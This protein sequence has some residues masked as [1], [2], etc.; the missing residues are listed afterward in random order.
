MKNKVL[1]LVL[2]LFFSGIKAQRVNDIKEGEVEYSVFFGTKNN[3]KL[4]EKVS[5]SLKVS[6]VG[7]S[8]VVENMIS[9]N[10]GARQVVK[11]SN[12][13][14]L[15]I[16]EVK[17][18]AKTKKQFNITQ[19]VLEKRGVY[20][21][22]LSKNVVYNEKTYNDQDIVIK[23]NISDLKWNITDETAVINGYKVTK[24]TAKYKLEKDKGK[25][26]MRDVVAWF[27]EDMPIKVAPMHFYGLP[28]LVVKLE[29][30]GI[31]YLLSSVKGKKVNVDYKINTKKMISEDKYM[32]MTN[33]ID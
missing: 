19:I 1:L 27:S 25:Q 4:K 2:S 17:P 26:I 15:S 23:Y 8:Q 14:S 3:Q 31:S 5:D 22:D 32:D 7:V 10:K 28:G 18:D 13:R 33:E 21:A 16:P 29:T 20:Y 6:G 11:F 9:S 12:D 24:A 30:K